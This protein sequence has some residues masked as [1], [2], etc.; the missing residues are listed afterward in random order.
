MLTLPNA[1]EANCQHN[2]RTSEIM[3]FLNENQ[4]TFSQDL[5]GDLSHIHHRAT[6]LSGIK[7]NTLTHHGDDSY[8]LDFS[9]DWVAHAGCGH[10]VHEDTEHQ[11]ITF[12]VDESGEIKF[13][14]LSY[15]ERSTFEEF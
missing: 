7:I 3:A 13:N 9:F 2:D 11:T 10:D 14:L 12:N 8:L 15:D 4:K 5:I 6:S 1:S